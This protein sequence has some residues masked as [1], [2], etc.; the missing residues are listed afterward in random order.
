MRPILVFYLSEM[1]KVATYFMQSV[2]PESLICIC[3]SARL[4]PLSVYMDKGHRQAVFNPLI[5]MDLGHLHTVFNPLVSFVGAVTSH[6]NISTSSLCLVTS[7]MISPLLGDRGP[8][9]S[10]FKWPFPLCCMSGI[11]QWTQRT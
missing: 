11:G 3:S 2:S 1:L 5:C 8:A 9:I 10:A 6:N 4:F 7:A